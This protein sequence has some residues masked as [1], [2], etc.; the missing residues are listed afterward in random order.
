MSFSGSLSSSVLRVKGQGIRTQGIAPASG[1][2]F[3]PLADGVAP[4]AKTDSSH[5]LCEG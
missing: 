5:T 2:V 1:I 3:R 4:F